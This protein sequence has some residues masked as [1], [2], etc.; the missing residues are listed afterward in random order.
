MALVFLLFI[1]ASHSAEAPTDL[2]EVRAVWLER[3]TRYI[4]W[5]ANSRVGDPKIAFTLCVWHDPAVTKLAQQLYADQRIKE[6][7]VQVIEL[8][9]PAA[10]I[11]CDLLYFPNAPERDWSKFSQ[12]L[13]AQ[14][15]LVVTVNPAGAERGT[16]INMYEEQGYQRF[17]IDVEQMKRIGLSVRS[18]LLQ[19]ARIVQ[20]GSPP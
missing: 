5:P 18:R 15:I 14:P 12:A 17:E 4:D 20:A 7:A 9:Q 10:A 2:I 3:F 8:I 11:D 19:V 6:K 1:N 13:S 16:H